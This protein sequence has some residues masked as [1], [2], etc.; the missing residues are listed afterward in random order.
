MGDPSSIS[1][2]L[3]SADPATQTAIGMVL[4]F[5]VL[6]LVTVFVPLIVRLLRL[7]RLERR[8]LELV[9]YALATSNVRGGS[10][11]SNADHAI[12]PEELR[13]AFA[14]SPISASYEEFERLWKRAARGGRQGRR[15]R[16]DDDLSRTTP[17]TSRP[18][19]EPRVDR[20]SRTHRPARHSKPIRDQHGRV[21]AASARC[22]ALS[23]RS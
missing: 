7:Y 5:A 13:G 1:Q 15:R 6:A 4:S 22:V 20:D 10:R 21:A 14:D 18:L 8:L 19:G 9:E 17:K 2:I 12:E 3:W 16:R 11:T 23:R